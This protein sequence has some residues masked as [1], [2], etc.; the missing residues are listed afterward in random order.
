MIGSTLDT[1]RK[2]EYVAVMHLD[3]DDFK[4]INTMWGEPLGDELILDIS[5][6]I[7][8]NLG[9]DDYL[10][11]TGSDEF[12]ILTQNLEDIDTYEDRV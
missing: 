4:T 3:I 5:H 10:A 6:R 2:N 9:E 8:A 7:K 12:Y 11:R 1:L